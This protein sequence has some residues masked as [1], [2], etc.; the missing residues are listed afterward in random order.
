MEN[1]KYLQVLIEKLKTYGSREQRLYGWVV[2]ISKQVSYQRLLYPD[3]SQTL[4]PETIRNNINAVSY[5]LTVYTRTGDPQTM[6]MMYVKID[7]L[8]SVEEQI[9][10]AVTGALAVKNTPWELVTPEL[11]GE[12]R[13]P[14]MAD[15]AILADP[16]AAA[17][18]IVRMA[19]DTCNTLEG[20]HV[21]YSELFVT[22]AESLRITSTG[23]RMRKKAS[24]IYYEIAM[25]KLPLPNRQE[26]HNNKNSLSI[27][28]LQIDRFIRQAAEEARVLGSVEVP[29]TD[30]KAVILV[31]GDVIN[32]IFHCLL[33]Q[34][35]V[36]REYTKRPYLKLEEKIY[37]GELLK[38]TD[39]VNLQLDPFI[40]YMAESTPY[41]KE[42]LNPAAGIVIENSTIRQHYVSYRMSQYLNR[43]RNP[44][45]GNIVLD[46]GTA[47]YAELTR[48]EPRV[49]EI[50]TF[51]SLLLNS[52]YLTYSSEIKLARE[53]DNTKGTVRYLKGGVV[54]GSIREN[55]CSCRFSNNR[56]KCNTFD[57]IYNETRAYLGPE[58]MLVRTGVAI[59]GK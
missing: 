2:A 18:K 9:E 33:E 47:S 44:V 13:S 36:S 51:S 19:S 54:S 31:Q 29:E 23:L 46:C 37:R 5:V 12:Y 30:E 7:P 39:L 22:M 24:S 59:S 45:S 58:Y 14:A 20:V 34:I 48:S 28:G 25:E 57:G 53:F 17:D 52:D 43:P 16:V 15:P 10:A 6:G 26:I 56:V 1:D 21:N 41:T 11:A 38:D 55:F 49:I 40:D 32:S 3:T 35:D 8:K 4:I 50:L 27:E 42:G